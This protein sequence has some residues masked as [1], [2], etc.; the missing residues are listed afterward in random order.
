MGW[1]ILLIQKYGVGCEERVSVGIL[2]GERPAGVISVLGILKAGGA[3][4]AA[5]PSPA[6][7]PGEPSLWS[8]RSH[9][10]VSNWG[11]STHWRG[12]KARRVHL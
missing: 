6:R 10:C 4:V 2:A 12:S 5:G 8:R 11:R 9:A 1:H 7:A 3:Y